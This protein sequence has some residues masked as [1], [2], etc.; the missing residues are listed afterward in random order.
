MV[1][2]NH[3]SVATM[4]DELSDKDRTFMFWAATATPDQIRGYFYDRARKAH[5]RFIGADGL[6]DLERD[7][8]ERDFLAPPS[9]AA[10]GHLAEWRARRRR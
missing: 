7:S 5:A 6:T 10:S 9:S 8:I 3:G 1:A 4:S 2:Q